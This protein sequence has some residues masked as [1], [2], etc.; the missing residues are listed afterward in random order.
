MLGLVYIIS[1]VKCSDIKIGD[2]HHI[3]III[4]LLLCVFISSGGTSLTL[5]CL[6]CLMHTI[7]TMSTKIFSSTDTPSSIPRIRFKV[8]QG[9]IVSPEIGNW[10]DALSYDIIIYVA[11]YM[12]LTAYLSQN[13][14]LLSLQLF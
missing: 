13:M 8:E 12:P 11:N 5:C 7:I 6:Q 10:S 2:G 3:T 14:H 4:D 1:P 9:S